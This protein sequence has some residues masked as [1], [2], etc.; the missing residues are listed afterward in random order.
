M[1][2]SKRIIC[3]LL[4]AYLLC[5]GASCTSNQASP[6]DQT[7]ITTEDRL[8]DAKNES[9]ENILSFAVEH[10]GKLDDSS[11]LKCPVLVNGYYEQVDFVTRWSRRQEWLPQADSLLNLIGDAARYGLFPRDYHYTRLQQLKRIIDTDSVMRLDAVL[12]SKTDLLLTDASLRLLHD[13]KYGRLKNDSVQLLSDTSGLSRQLMQLQR[14]MMEASSVQD[15]IKEL[16]PRYPGYHAL[17]EALPGFLDSMDQRYYTYVPYPFKKN[18]EGDSLRFIRKLEQRLTESNCISPGKSLPDSARLDSA[19]RKYQRMKGQKPDGKISA[20]LVKMMNNT[21]QEKLRRISITLDRYKLLPDSLPPQYI[22]V[23]IPAFYL[24][25]HDSDSVALES[26]IICGKP[27][28]PTPVLTSAIS[29]M[30][31]YPTWTVPTSIIAKQYLP[32]LKNNPNY[33]S[34][35]GLKLIN[36]EGEVISGSSVNWSKYSKG[37]PYKVMQASGDNNAL[38]VIK[39]NFSNPHSV[40]LHDTNERY[41]FKNASRAYSHG[42]VRVQEWDKLAAWIARNDSLRLKPGDSLRYTA[43]SV[44]TWIAAKKNRRILVK[45]R[46]PLF[47]TY[48]SCEGKNG[49]VK[50]YEDI[51][52]DDKAL[53]EK[54]FNQP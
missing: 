40:Y 49:R 51:Y 22:W 30:V 13:I 47:I 12:W 25:V 36:A 19:I 6:G 10:T 4:L 17:K 8:E 16:E 26:R 15:F 14:G 44:R 28:T 52:G 31:I 38:G 29:D 41:L 48:F 53:R 34:R 24:Q 1:N 20:G 37:I 46:I 23:N 50:F 3:M 45:N 27:V 7:L 42:C 21:D 11:R 18:D 32:K 39:F 9:L 35:L 2:A 43:D 54:Y 33:L 5:V